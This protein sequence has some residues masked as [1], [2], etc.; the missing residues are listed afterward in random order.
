MSRLSGL[1]RPPY[2][3]STLRF[4]WR[5]YLC[6]AN[7]KLVSIELFGRTMPVPDVGVEAWQL[8]EE[9]HEAFGYDP[10]PGSF[11]TYV[12]RKIGGTT[13]WS[14]HAYA[15]AG[16]KDPGHNPIKAG[17]DW[18]DTHYRQPHVHAL[19]GIRT[20]NGAQVFAWGGQW[21]AY[22]DLMHWYL[23]CKPSDLA[24]GIDLGSVSWLQED[25]LDYRK[26]I[27]VWGPNGLEALRIAGRWTGIT[28]HYFGSST[29]AEDKN[30]V[31][32]IF[33]RDA[34]MSIEGPAVPAPVIEYVKV[35][36]NL[37]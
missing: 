8:F 25:E 32:I 35:V 19:L 16:D 31:E 34:L 12:C 7:R 11:W 5:K 3:S 14:Q 9:S 30:L 13:V 37:A 20:N 22:Q 1:P 2:S 18:G 6:N 27:D 23:V 36:K 29:P 28:R 21:N 17:Q 33:A 15:A 10:L 24:S 4:W 26:I